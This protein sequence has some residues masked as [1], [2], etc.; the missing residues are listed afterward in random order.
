MQ[1][2][3][4]VLNK[5]PYCICC[6]FTTQV[7]NA[8]KYLFEN[9]IVLYTYIWRWWKSIIQRGTQKKPSHVLSLRCVFSTCN[10]VLF[11][12]ENNINLTISSTYSFEHACFFLSTHFSRS[13]LVLY[14]SY[15]NKHIWIRHC[16]NDAW[17]VRSHHN[18]CI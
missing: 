12:K 7:I 4:I 13:R 14:G 16:R 1:L 17:Y 2:I 3:V 18:K 5:H 15:I 9:F 11:H 8:H 6:A 10:F